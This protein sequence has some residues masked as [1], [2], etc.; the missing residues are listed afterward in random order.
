[1]SRIRST[2]PMIL[3]SVA[4]FVS[5]R[6]TPFPRTIRPRQVAE[7]KAMRATRC[8]LSTRPLMPFAPAPLVERTEGAFVVGYV[9]L[10]FFRLEISG[11]ARAIL[12]SRQARPGRPSGASV[13]HHLYQ[14]GAAQ[15]SPAVLNTP[16]T[17][18]PL[19]GTPH[20]HV[21]V[22][23]PCMP[24]FIFGEASSKESTVRRLWGGGSRQ[25]H[26]SV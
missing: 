6:L 10:F 17:H 23:H 18:R 14:C 5:I 9:I 22:G 3:A 8:S 7:R 2:P 4:W 19:A 21:A 25:I 26:G 13:I 12:P 15:Y 16:H 11:A 1:M 20:L 24:S